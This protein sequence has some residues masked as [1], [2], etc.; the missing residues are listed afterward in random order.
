M[1]FEMNK[2]FILIT[3]ISLSACKDKVEDKNEV[4]RPVRYEV[5]GNAKTQYTRTFSGVA[6]S[7]DEIE[8]SFRSNG[9]ITVFNAKVGQEIKKGEL[10]A[11]LD[12]VQANLA[13]EQSVSALNAANS[14]LKTAKSK[15][16]RMKSLYEKGSKS[17]SDYEDAKNSYQAALDQY[18]SAKRNKSIQRSQINYGIIKAPKDGIIAAKNYGL[19]ENVSSGQTIAVLNAGKE[20][21]VLVGIPENNINRV[22]I[23]MEVTLNF[24]SLNDQDFKGSIIEIAPVIESNSA[25]YPVKIG[26]TNP[27]EN[28]RPGMAANVIFNFQEDNNSTVNAMIVPL[29]AVGEDGNGNFVFVLVSEDGKTGVVNKRTIKIGN[30]TELGFK[31]IGGLEEGDKVATAGLQS[32]LDGQKVK[33]QK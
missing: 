2:I 32:L 17:L 9:I 11:K 3:L 7:G 6:K 23:N 4:L 13:Y 24:S 5:I 14:A 29:K 8:L 22:N 28:I 31:V 33:L 25:T 21:N 20:I 19:N 15:L 18:E 26:I 10:I 27:T 16:E 30:L 1:K 12:N